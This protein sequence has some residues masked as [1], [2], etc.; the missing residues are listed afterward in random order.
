MNDA[1]FQRTLQSVLFDNKYDRYVAKR[2]S[3]KLN[4]KGLSKVGFS[5]KLFKRKEERQNKD[6]SIALLVDCSGSMSGKKAD[7]A[8][9]SAQKL[10][11]H[12]ASAKINHTVFGF[13]L[14]TFQLKPWNVSYDNTLKEKLRFMLNYLRIF[15][16]EES[17]SKGI[18][19][20]IGHNFDL[21]NITSK[22]PDSLIGISRIDYDAKAGSGYN[23]DADALMIAA[24][25]LHKQP[26]K[27]ILIMLSDG[28]PAHFYTKYQNADF[29]K[30]NYQI[31][32]SSMPRMKKVVKDIMDMGIDI[33]SIGIQSDAVNKY[34]PAGKT[35]SI[36]DVSQLYDHIIKIIKLNLKRG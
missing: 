11:K 5:D 29:P 22:M 36:Y 10:S 21:K 14:K 6:Y 16:K 1:T 33:Q 24:K 23:N 12:L 28:E 18:H 20:Y 30:T 2:R 9:D 25:E 17:N 8:F 13:N 26:G 31:G 3:G 7:V 19:E 15:Y 32:D 27:K 4:F 34:Y 35:C